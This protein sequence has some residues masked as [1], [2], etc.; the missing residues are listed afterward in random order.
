MKNAS[1]ELIKKLITL[2][3]EFYHKYGVNDIY[4][5]S[6]IF[7]ILI[8]D[9]LN[10]K[11][12]PGHSGSRDGKDKFGEYEYKHYKE[13][14]SNHT[15]TFND[16]SDTTIHK[17]NSCH[18][19]LF[20]H[21][22]DACDPYTFDWCYEVPGK[23]MANYLSKT[24][25]KIKN[26]RKMINVST[27][28]IE[29]NLKINKSL[30][31]YR[32]GEYSNFLSKVFAISKQLEKELGVSNILTSNKL[33]ELL[34]SLKT[35][36]KIISEQ[37]KHDAIDNQ[38]NYYEY[39]VSKS[40]S[41]SFEDISPTVIK[42]FYDEEGIILAKV[43]KEKMKVLDIFLANPKKMVAVLNRKLKE[44]EERYKSKNKEVRRLQVTI[45]RKDLST[46][47]AKKIY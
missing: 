44:K 46:I 16:F 45:N 26:A 42:K 22:N 14:S 32:P 28:Q 43:D 27:R 19:I 4:T 23:T 8:A 39:K 36:H 31:K 20:C 47:N 25:G 11:L 34:I 40:F 7:E 41:W 12:I 5:N 3:R 35:G 18:S 21:I 10:H 29:Q 2:Q 17:L 13:S 33:W 38:G 6:K 24:V 37:K 1:K 30:I 15:W 9:S